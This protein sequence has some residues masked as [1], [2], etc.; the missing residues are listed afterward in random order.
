M[1]DLY[2]TLPDYGLY[3]YSD[4]A[5]ARRIIANAKQRFGLK[6]SDEVKKEI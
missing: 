5:Q 1:N 3:T 4:Y 6:L 2:E